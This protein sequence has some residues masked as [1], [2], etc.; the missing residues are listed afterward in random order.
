[1]PF[2]LFEVLALEG[3]FG[4]EGINPLFELVF[5]GLYTGCGLVKG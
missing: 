1:L 2:A 3:L 5:E 4:Y